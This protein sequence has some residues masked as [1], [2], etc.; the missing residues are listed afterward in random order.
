VLE[1]GD[2]I[3]E[4]EGEQGKHAIGFYVG[5]GV[6]EGLAELV[7]WGGDKSLFS[8]LTRDGAGFLD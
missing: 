4:E 5:A 2:F 1:G 6:V 8:N 7:F 3:F